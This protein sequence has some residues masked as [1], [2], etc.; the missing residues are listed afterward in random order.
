[1]CEVHRIETVSL[2]MSSFF[3]DEP[4]AKCLQLGEPIDFAQ[5]VIDDALRD[6]CSFVAFNTQ[7]NQLTG[8]CLN[9]VKHR[10]GVEHS[11]NE[12][13]EKLDYILR[14]LDHM[15]QKID[16]FH[17][18]DTND[19]LHIFMISVDKTYRGHGLA[20]RLILASIDCA[21]NTHIGGVYAEATNIYSLNCFKQQGFE[22]Y[23]RV[24]YRDYDRM[25]LADLT[26]VSHDQCQL[27]A[28]KL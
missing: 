3:R 10:N 25:R 16:L 28:K 6:Q 17:E 23:H 20:S 26:D 1:M 2:L 8:V 12:W 15:H 5:R 11:T 4:L 13:E 22:V 21:K 27:V 24:I 18:F 9:Q 19:L 7:T 14:L